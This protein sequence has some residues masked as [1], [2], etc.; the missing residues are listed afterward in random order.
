MVRLEN[1]QVRDLNGWFIRY[2]EGFKNDPATVRNIVLKE[3]HTKQVCREISAIGTDL[4]LTNDELRFAEI[5][6]L[7]HDIGRFEQYARYK[8][9]VDRRSEDHAELGVTV[10]RRLGVL[11]RWGEATQDLVFRIIRYH[12]R[13]SLPREETEP[14]LFFSKLLRDADKLD[15][16]RVVTDYYRREDGERNG[17]LELDLPDTPGFSDAVYLDLM[18]R[19]IVDMKHVMTLNDFKLLQIG[20]IFD[21]NFRPTL[22]AVR[23][24]GYLEMIR[25]VLPKSEKIDALFSDITE[26]LEERLTPS[27]NMPEGKRSHVYGDV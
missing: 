14:C 22:L 24:R 5:I 25:H 6:A 9:F 21:V 15:I 11:H 3:E 2:V 12:N 1:E 4:G 7:F 26:Y 17:A 27:K 8:T 18:R 19:K 13:A 10:L 23:S 16:W 20:W